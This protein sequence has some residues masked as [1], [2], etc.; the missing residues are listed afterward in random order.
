[1]TPDETTS[2][3][4]YKTKERKYAEELF[5]IM[6]DIKSYTFTEGKICYDTEIILNNDVKILGEI[7][8][9]QFDIHKYDSYILEV[10]KLIS[11]IKKYKKMGSDRI[12]YIN[13]FKGEYDGIKT[14]IIF[15]LTPRIEIWKTIRPKIYK[16]YMN[17]ETF[18]S[19]EDKISKDV[20]LLEYDCN[21]DCQGILSV[22]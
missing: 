7:K 19:T 6:P 16:K 20:I 2:L 4:S 5:K 22:N 13:F 11:L 21:I 17:R 14:F 9:R 8:I 12:Y 1:M 15:D 10:A 3:L 18:K